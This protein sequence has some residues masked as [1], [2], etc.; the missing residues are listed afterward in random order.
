MVHPWPTCKPSCR[1]IK[2]TTH[3][4]NLQLMYLIKSE[5]G[6][7]TWYEKTGKPTNMYKMEELI[8]IISEKSYFYNSSVSLYTIQTRT[9]SVAL[10]DDSYLCCQNIILIF[11]F[12][13]IRM[14]RCC[15]CIAKKS[16]FFEGWQLAEIGGGGGICAVVNHSFFLESLLP[17]TVPQPRVTTSPGLTHPQQEHLP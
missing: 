1:T 13:V 12:N 16:T 7:K 10:S 4:G 9:W 8:F 14:R 17:A 11:S 2:Q 3:A 15:S 6:N 5:I